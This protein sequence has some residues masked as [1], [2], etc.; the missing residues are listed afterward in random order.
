MEQK[1]IEAIVRH[2]LTNAKHIAAPELAQ[3]V[4]ENIHEKVI[5]KRIE[6]KK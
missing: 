5:Q 2:R 3:L 1:Q 6:E 4:N